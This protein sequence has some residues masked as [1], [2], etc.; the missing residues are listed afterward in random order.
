MIESERFLFDRYADFIKIGCPKLS[1]TD[2][3][4]LRKALFSSYNFLLLNLS[5]RLFT[6]K[7]TISID[8]AKAFLLYLKNCEID[9]LRDGLMT[10]HYR[11]NSGDPNTILPLVATDIIL[12]DKLSRTL[13]LSFIDSIAIHRVIGYEKT[14][15]NIFD[16]LLL[17][18][19]VLKN[20]TFEDCL[21]MYTRTDETLVTSVSE[22]KTVS[23][24]TKNCIRTI[25]H[26]SF[27]PICKFQL[28]LALKI[29][30]SGVNVNN[31]FP[32]VGLVENGIIKINPV[33]C[34]MDGDFIMSL[35]LHEATH[36]YMQYESRI[37][38]FLETYSS[39]GYSENEMIHAW[40][41][42]KEK[43]I[44]HALTYFCKDIKTYKHFS[45]L[46]GNTGN[47]MNSALLELLR[48]NRKDQFVWM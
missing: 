24:L 14:F 15:F 12:C 5:D 8:V 42:A 30:A 22:Y 40:S 18:L 35:L 45:D 48:L 13:I 4:S 3:V 21:R 29:I 47:A 27:N 26:N 23:D 37:D 1:D 19:C 33:K 20:L 9:F 34:G 43:S 25:Y 39:F 16:E 7:D 2:R 44:D 31:D 38:E 36:I 17:T 10:L 46:S 11:G 41:F 28:R 32:Y 6:L